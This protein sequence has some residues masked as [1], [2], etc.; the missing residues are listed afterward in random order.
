MVCAIMSER[1]RGID[2]ADEAV[3]HAI[4]AE[5]SSAIVQAEGAQ[6]PVPEI[7]WRREGM[8]GYLGEP[9]FDPTQ[10]RRVIAALH[11]SLTPRLGDASPVQALW[12]WGA[13]KLL[14]ESEG[15]EGVTLLR[16]ESESGAHVLQIGMLGLPDHVRLAGGWAASIQLQVFGE[17]PKLF[18]GEPIVAWPYAAQSRAARK[19][20]EP[21]HINSIHFAALPEGTEGRMLDWLTTTM[22]DAETFDKIQERRAAAEATLD[23]DGR[24]VEEIFQ[25]TFPGQAYFGEAVGRLSLVDHYTHAAWQTDHPAAI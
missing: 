12:H 10:T 13:S 2:V 5:V 17:A 7:K 21:A 11:R 9:L 23:S 25:E 22:A 8:Q 4:T 1:A 15:I 24:P 20:K 18:H 16:P 3:R 6:A 14:A 19:G